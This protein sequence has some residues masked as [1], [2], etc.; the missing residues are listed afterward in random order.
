MTWIAL[1]PRLWHHDHVRGEPPPSS[2]HPMAGK[3]GRIAMVAM[4]HRDHDYGTLNDTT[5]AALV[6]ARDPGAVRHVT[7]RNHQRLFR[8]AFAILGNRAEAED[9]VPSTYMR[10]LAEID[11]VEGRRA[12]SPWLTRI[13]NN[14]ALG[15]NRSAQRRVGKEG[16]STVSIWW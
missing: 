11:R 3:N 5:L 2:R 15:R 10:A 14:A 8:T 16:G 9:A 12:L 6:A 1:P 13:A 7:A 4:I